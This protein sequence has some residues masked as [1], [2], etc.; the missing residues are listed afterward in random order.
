MKQNIYHLD[1]E[2]YSDVDI[3]DVGAFRYAEDPSTEILILAI[4]RNDEP[5]VVWDA[6]KYKTNETNNI[7]AVDLL[8]EAVFDSLDG[9]APIYAHNVYFEHAIFQS[10][11]QR[12]FNIPR[13]QIT[14]WRCTQAMCRLAG[15]PESLDKAGDFLNLD[16]TKDDDGKRLIRKFSCPRKPTKK[17]PSSRI[18][19]QDDPVD[20][21]RFVDYCVQ[22]VETERELHKTLT[23]F[24]MKGETLNTFHLDLAMN[25]RGLPLNVPAL[26]H[27]SK[28]LEEYEGDAAEQFREIVGLNHTQ[29]DK[30]HAWAKAR[31]YT[32]DNLQADTVAK[33]LAN[34]GNA[35]KECVDAL[36]LRAKVSFAATKKIPKM[37]EVVCEDGHAKGQFTV[38]GATRTHR[39]SGRDLQPQNMKRS[40]PLTAAT[41]PYIRGMSLEDVGTYLGPVQSVLAQSIRH[42]MG[43]GQ[44][45]LQAD[46]S[47]VEACGNPWLCGDEKTCQEFREGKPKYAMMASTIFNVPVDQVMA[48]HKAQKGKKRF[49]GKQTVLGCGYQ[50]WWPTFRATCASYNFVP[51]PDMVDEFRARWPG[52]WQEAL[53]MTGNPEPWTM[54]EMEWPKYPFMRCDNQYTRKNGQRVF[55]RRRLFAH[56][57]DEVGRGKIE[58]PK[59]PTEAEFVRMTF[60]DLAFRAVRAWRDE[61]PVIV[62]AWRNIDKAAKDAIRNPGQVFEGTPKIKF[63]VTKKPGFPALVMFLPGGHKLVYPKAFIKEPE[64]DALGGEQKSSICFWGI[65]PTKSVWGWC[66]THGGKLL[67]NATQATCGKIMGFGAYNAWHKKNYLPYMLVHD[68]AI[69]P[70]GEGQSVE[71][72]MRLLCELPPWADGFPLQADGNEI[73]F[74][75]KT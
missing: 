53:A 60:D 43:N 41:F 64:K 6:L 1:F 27:A 68:E 61:H 44:P 75:M 8:I 14:Q 7:E 62:Q 69:T 4:A 59:A 15:I 5:P 50:M 72:L 30:V 21:Q 22:D 31:G 54:E 63:Q 66:Y 35:S 48:E 57:F 55:Q 25:S 56:A 45:L 32:A 10:V 67:G 2:T 19:P 39:W 13:P 29:R 18:L 49:I 40:T 42:F 11:L 47:A 20:F 71:E 70:K 36:T 65:P 16:L 58:D 74:Y 9:G 51:P 73:P 37:M 34:P 3:K 23:A 28:L 12:Q 46:Y 38:F 33:F 24:E 52:M 26:E 17:N